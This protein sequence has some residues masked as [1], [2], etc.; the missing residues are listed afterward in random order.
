MQYLGI[1]LRCVKNTFL[2]GNNKYILYFWKLYPKQSNIGFTITVHSWF[3]SEQQWNARFW[4]LG[5]DA[6]L[7]VR[8]HIT[9][10]CYHSPEILACLG[11]SSGWGKGNASHGHGVNGFVV[12]SISQRALCCLG[13]R[14]RAPCEKWWHD[15]AWLAWMLIQLSFCQYFLYAWNV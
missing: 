4:I 15:T 8:K 2:T 7:R 1:T 5:S 3:L 13:Q 9:N 11:R 12:C 6:S 14:L 10:S